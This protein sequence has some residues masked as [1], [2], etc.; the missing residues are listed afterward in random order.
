MERFWA[1]ADG[2]RA[3]TAIWT[4]AASIVDKKAKETPERGLRE[5]SDGS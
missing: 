2:A 5:R 1:F 4:A 3:A